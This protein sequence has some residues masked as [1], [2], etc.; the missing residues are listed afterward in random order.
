MVSWYYLKNP[1]PR[2]ILESKKEVIM[3][4][5]KHIIALCLLLSL[6]AP[7]MVIAQ[8]K[9]GAK[10]VQKSGLTFKDCVKIT[11]AVTAAIVLGFFITKE[12]QKRHNPTMSD[13]TNSIFN[14]FSKSGNKA[15]EAAEDV[16][17][18]LGGKP[19]RKQQFRQMRNE[20]LQSAKALKNQA[21]QAT[22]DFIDSASQKI[23]DSISKV[24]RKK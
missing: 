6:A 9:E 11:G 24:R 18:E 14:F 8:D 22:Y 5:M 2:L 1:L 15:K 10:T 21:T 13:R 16:Y 19:T 20:A 23:N 4:F 12:Y 17:V 3:K 7:S